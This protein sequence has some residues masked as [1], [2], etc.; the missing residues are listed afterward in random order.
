MSYSSPRVEKA[1]RARTRAAFGRAALAAALLLA[2]PSPGAA[3]PRDAL[4]WH[5]LGALR[6]GMSRRQF[7]AIGLALE[8]A[9]DGA[10]DPSTPTFNWSGCVELPLRGSPQTTLM[11]EDGL[12]VRIAVTGSQAATRAGIRVGNDAAQVHRAYARTL[13]S[14]GQKYDERRRN[15][16]L[17]SRDGRHG[18]VFVIED[19][20]VVEIRA[21]LAGAIGHDGGCPC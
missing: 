4:S 6:V 13:E 14:S 5:G 17:G 20:R 18:F 16:T 15:L 1:L 11:F 10:A 3:A 21:G 9:G 7:D 2:A 12:L 19:E 8:P